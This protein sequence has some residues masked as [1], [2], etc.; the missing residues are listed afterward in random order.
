MNDFTRNYS[1]GKNYYF[2]GILQPKYNPFREE[3]S[4][5]CDGFLA[6]VGSFQI[7]SNL[8]TCFESK[9]CDDAAVCVETS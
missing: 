7:S 2:H 1:F 6:D 8:E 3:N 5:I 9:A 4:I